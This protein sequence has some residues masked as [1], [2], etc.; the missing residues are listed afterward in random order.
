M[1][2]ASFLSSPRDRVLPTNVGTVVSVSKLLRERSTLLWCVLLAV[3]VGG[4]FLPA[5]HKGFINYDDPVY[6]YSNPHVT[7]GLTCA[8]R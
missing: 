2:E 8:A 7:G 3:I 1:R 5:L 4:T 6:V